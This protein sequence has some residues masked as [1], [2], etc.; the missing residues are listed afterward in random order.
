[1]NNIVN[2]ST[3]K[4]ILNYLKELHRKIDDNN[5]QSTNVEKSYELLMKTSF[6]KEI[7][8]KII[9]EDSSDKDF[10]IFAKIIT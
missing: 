9:K 10:I 2:F 5:Y 7:L 4:Q 3:S 8:K 1:L 6:H